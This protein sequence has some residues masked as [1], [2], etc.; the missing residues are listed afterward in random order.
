MKPNI[1]IVLRGHVRNALSDS[2]LDEF[3]V[4]LLNYLEFDL[5]MQSWNR[6]DASKTW[7]GKTNGGGSRKKRIKDKNRI[8][9]S[10][11]IMQD[12]FS[13]FAPSIV[14]RIK[15]IKIL[16]EDTINLFGNLDGRVGKSRCPLISWK[17][18]WYGVHDIVSE[19][20][21][22]GKYDFIL[23]TRFDIFDKSLVDFCGR[24]FPR[25]K[26]PLNH[27]DFIR[28][29]VN[30]KD[31]LDPQTVYSLYNR[32]GCDN[33]YLSDVSFM[34]KVVTELH[35]NLDEIIKLAMEQNLKTGH[36]EIIFKY[37]CQTNGSFVY[38]HS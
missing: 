26:P 4:E 29:F 33:F 31:S 25:H 20:P 9:T 36:Q 28:K 22:N 30:L 13:Y 27:H 2:L 11:S 15:S 21:E 38:K 17:R 23:N 5:Y 7:T 32:V 16:N 14:D 8:T 3:L 24:R 10:Q 37:C 1:A 19:V 35:T 34:K 18:M 6:I 12:I